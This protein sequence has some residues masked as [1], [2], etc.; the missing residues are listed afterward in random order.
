[1]SQ[2]L[3]PLEV[4]GL[5][6]SVPGVLALWIVEH[7]DVV[8]HILLGFFA[9]SVGPSSD[10]LTLQQVKEALSD[11]VVMAV[12]AA[13][14]RVLQIVGPKERCPV[15]A[16]ELAALVRMDQ[17][18]FPGLSPPCRREQRLQDNFGRL[19]ALHRPSNDTTRDGGGSENDPGNRFPDDHR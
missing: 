18:L 14:H 1:M 17:N 7:L 19:A 3:L 10:P 15:H 9:C 6:Y 4:D 8:G 16:G 5:Q 11:R 13:A 2:F 12:S